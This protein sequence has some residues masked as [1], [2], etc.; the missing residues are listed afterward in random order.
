[1]EVV[2]GAPGE[3]LIIRHDEQGDASIFVMGTLLAARR[4]QAFAASSAG[5][6]PSSSPE[7]SIARRDRRGLTPPGEV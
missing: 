1:M 2:F 6:T 5:S 4:V 7:K 3:R